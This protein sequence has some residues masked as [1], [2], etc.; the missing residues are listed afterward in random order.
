[1][2]TVFRHLAKRDT[3]E[4]SPSISTRGVE[5]ATSVEI[6]IYEEFR[7]RARAYGHEKV[8]PDNPWEMLCL[9]QHF[10]VPTRLL[11]WTSNPLVAAYFAV[12]DLNMDIEAAIW[13][14]N[15]TK[16]LEQTEKPA[17]AKRPRSLETLPT[18]DVTFLRNRWFERGANASTHRGG[19]YF[20]VIQ[21][22][23]IDDRMK[24][25][26]GMFTVFISIGQRKEHDFVWS[27]SLWL[28]QS[29]DEAVI[30]KLRIPGSRKLD[31]LRQLRNMGISRNHL[32]PEL[33]GLGGYL[34]ILQK[35]WLANTGSG[36]PNYT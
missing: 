27:H 26:A 34:T 32:F 14:L 17:W 22:P 28:E 4:R 15:I 8:N 5:D 20:T 24:I 11:D 36:G 2:P 35:D 3:E 19:S 7:D 25:Q 33:A 16:F 30:H 21:P 1:V 10:G 29:D 18:K 13:C 9:A 12:E 6:R 31:L 23:D